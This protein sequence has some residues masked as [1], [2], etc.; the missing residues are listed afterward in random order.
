MV[1]LKIVLDETYFQNVGL[2]TMEAADTNE[3]DQQIGHG[4]VIVEGQERHIHQRAGCERSMRPFRLAVDMLQ[5]TEQYVKGELSVACGLQRRLAKPDEEWAMCRSTGKASDSK[6]EMKS[7][8]KRRLNIETEA[9]N[10]GER[11]L[12]GIVCCVSVS[13]TT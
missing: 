2:K 10:V 11:A 1:A 3:S 12:A 9:E 13:L 4:R 8:Q 7:K 6:E 5:T